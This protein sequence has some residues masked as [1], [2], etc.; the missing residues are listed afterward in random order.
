MT[1]VMRSCYGEQVAEPEVTV[2]HCGRSGGRCAGQQCG[3]DL[4]PPRSKRWINGFQCATPPF[5]LCR[6]LGHLL[7]CSSPARRGRC[8]EDSPAW[9]QPAGSARRQLRDPAS[10]AASRSNSGSKALPSMWLIANSGGT[11]GGSPASV[12]IT[13]GTGTAVWL[14]ARNIRACRKTSRCA[15]GRTPGGATLTTTCRSLKT[16]A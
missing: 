14:S 3:G 5:D 15:I 16:A 4:P 2:Y 13:S 7:R 10:A 6:R 12:K 8:D 9:L 11:S 1:A